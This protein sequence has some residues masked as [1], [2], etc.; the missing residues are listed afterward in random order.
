MLSGKQVVLRAW[1]PEDLPAL[2]ALRNDVPLQRQLMAQPKGS[3]LEQVRAW[4]TTRSQTADALF[5]VVAERPSNQTLG[6]VQLLDIDLFHGNGRLGIC[7]AP[8]AQ[9]R[10]YGG[11]TLTLLEAYVREV[12]GL[13][14]IVLEVL[15]SNDGAI[16]LYLR[17]NYREVGRWQRHFRQGDDYADVVIMEK[18]LAT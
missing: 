11:Q 16:R 9:G 18:L 10:G 14:K 12:F 1:I 7:L 15:A 17:H 13:R 6:Y 3:S 5:F 8:Q 4:L 2:Q